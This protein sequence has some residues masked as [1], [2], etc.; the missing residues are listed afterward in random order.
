MTGAFGR[1]KNESENAVEHR[2]ATLFAD[3]N[4]L[5]T[6]VMANDYIARTHSQLNMFA[7]LFFATLDPRTGSLTYINA[8]HEAP[9]I[10]GRNGIKSR[11]GQTGPAVGMMPGSD[12]DLSQY[13]LE[14]GDILFTFTDGVPETRNAAGDFFTEKRLRE[15]LAEP[16]DSAGT[17]IK[18]IESNLIAH[19]A[20][21]DQF[22]DITMLAVRWSPPDA[23]AGHPAAEN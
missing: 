21:A 13:Q 19:I 10:I 6:V 22:D 9:M 11:L 1:K 2:L 12:F 4:A 8:G 20:Q 7:T 15:L 3:L 16:V 14:P 17:L 5:N 23:A 18:R